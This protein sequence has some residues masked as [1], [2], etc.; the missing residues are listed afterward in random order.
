MKLEALSL[1]SGHVAVTDNRFEKAKYVSNFG[2]SLSH[3]GAN[4]SRPYFPRP[5]EPKF[6]RDILLR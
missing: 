2:G 1:F 6:D 3:G 5:L 4:I